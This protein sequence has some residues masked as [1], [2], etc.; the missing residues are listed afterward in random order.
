MADPRS[1]TAELPALARLWW[2]FLVTGVVWLLVAMV[3]L[4]FDEQSLTTIGV[5]MGIVFLGAAST[6]ILASMAIPTWKWAHR[7]LAVLFGLGAI[8]AFTEPE[9][10]FWALAAAFAFLLVF[11]GTFNIVAA[12]MTRAMNPLWVLGLIVGILELLLGF[13][14]SQQIDPASATLLI[15]WIGFSALLR[16]MSQIALAFR[17]HAE[18]A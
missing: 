3:V 14:A 2:V 15:L 16:G 11:T 8:W 12:V 18:R 5:I 17:L 9:S 4:R 1:T 7:V 10:A 6:E 13:W